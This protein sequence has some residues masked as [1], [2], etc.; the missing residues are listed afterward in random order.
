L[1]FDAQMSAVLTQTVPWRWQ[2]PMVAEGATG[3]A[4]SAKIAGGK[5]LVSAAAGAGAAIAPVWQPHHIEK[6]HNLISGTA[7]VS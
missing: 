2:W 5:G 1:G 4:L 6:A 7:P 3:L